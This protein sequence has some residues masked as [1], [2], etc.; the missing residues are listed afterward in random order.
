MNF[1]KILIA[2]ISAFV[3]L[4]LGSAGPAAPLCDAVCAA[5]FGWWNPPALLACMLTCFAGCFHQDTQVL[6]RSADGST[7]LVKIGDIQQG[8]VLRSLSP[9]GKDLIW[10][11]VYAVRKHTGP[12]SFKILEVEDGNTVA[13]TPAHVMIV[14]RNGREFAV[15]ASDV[16]LTDELPMHN[17]DTAQ[18]VSIA[19]S[20][21]F[22]KYEVVTKSGNLLVGGRLL[23]STLCDDWLFEEPQAQI[24]EAPLWQD[25]WS[26]WHLNHTSMWKRSL[27]VDDVHT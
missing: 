5:M 2:F 25:V 7:A 12:S 17:G 22:V 15:R 4:Q 14:T 27:A 10:E 1:S 11:T 21:D 9:G 24:D 13:V 8:D 6:T 16:Q 3:V 19:D 26:N 23:A 20:I 18:I